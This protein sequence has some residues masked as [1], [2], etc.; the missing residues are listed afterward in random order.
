MSV[1]MMKAIKK[2]GE[3]VFAKTVSLSNLTIVFK[4]PFVHK[5]CKNMP[6]MLKCVFAKKNVLKFH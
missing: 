2:D 4:T 1:S 5:I 6:D 3:V